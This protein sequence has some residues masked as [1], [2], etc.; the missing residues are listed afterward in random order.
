MNVSQVL[1]DLPCIIVVGAPIGKTGMLRKCLMHELQSH[2]CAPTLG[3]EVHP[4]K[5]QAYIYDIGS[6]YPGSCAKQFYKK[7][8]G[9]L[10]VDDSTPY[11]LDKLLVDKKVQKL[12]P[13]CSIQQFET[14][15]SSLLA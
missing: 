3:V 2:G 6:R 15:V 5:E 14:A 12:N 10:H 7:C 4:Y 11:T 1:E 8:T 13:Q 9:V